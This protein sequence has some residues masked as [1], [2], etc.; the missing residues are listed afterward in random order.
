MN[1]VSE[2]V[3][4]IHALIVCFNCGNLFKLVILVLLFHVQVDREGLSRVL[5]FK[6]AL[7]HGKCRFLLVSTLVG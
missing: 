2:L 3:W 1:L 4:F 6:A 5:C 7:F